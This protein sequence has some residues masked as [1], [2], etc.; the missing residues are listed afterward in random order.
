MKRI[1][2]QDDERNRRFIELTAFDFNQAMRRR[3]LESGTPAERAA[4]VRR[5]TRWY[6]AFLVVVA[7]LTFLPSLLPS[8]P[9]PT[10]IPPHV[11]QAGSVVSVQLHDSTFSTSSSVHTERGVYQVM[12]AVSWAVGDTVTLQ[13]DQQGL[14]KGVK[15]LCIESKI[16]SGCFTL[17]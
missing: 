13:V 3:L 17:R 14:H 10:P 9:K 5:R 16:K 8:A 2:E 6:A 7:I 4:Y 12:G 15:R 11:E 1:T